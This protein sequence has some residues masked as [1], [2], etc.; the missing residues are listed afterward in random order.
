MSGYREVD[1]VIDHNS[2]IKRNRVKCL[3]CGAV[4]ESMSVHHFVQCDCPNGT[5]TDGGLNYQRYGG[6]DMS[7]VQLIGYEEE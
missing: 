1:V 2:S 4:L 6:K 7:F 5:F 3:Y